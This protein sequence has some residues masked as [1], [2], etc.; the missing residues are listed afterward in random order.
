LLNNLLYVFIH[1]VGDIYAKYYIPINIFLRN[2]S[3]T[4]FLDDNIPSTSQICEK[5]TKIKMYM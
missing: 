4:W 2:S 1:M 5:H 3:R